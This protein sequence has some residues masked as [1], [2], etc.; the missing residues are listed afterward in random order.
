MAISKNHSRD[1]AER[2]SVFSCFVEIEVDPCDPNPCLNNGT[3]TQVGQAP[4]SNF[5]CSCTADF[6]GDICEDGKYRYG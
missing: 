2:L 1:T 5:T 3:C 4:T 6:T